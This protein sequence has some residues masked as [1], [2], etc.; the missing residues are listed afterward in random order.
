MLNLILLNGNDIMSFFEMLLA[1]YQILMNDESSKYEEACDFSTP[2]NFLGEILLNR[3]CELILECIHQF[4]K[5]V[6]FLECPWRGDARCL[7]VLL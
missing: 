1:D 7:F 6:R 5:M 4:F 3:I 2:V